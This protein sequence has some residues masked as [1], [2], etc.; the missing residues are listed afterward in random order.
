MKKS[1]GKKEIFCL[2]CGLSSWAV[3]F[4]SLL[5]MSRI[6]QIAADCLVVIWF[7]LS[8]GSVLLGI[9]SRLW[10]G[11]QSSSCLRWGMICGTVML[12]VQVMVFGVMFFQQGT[13]WDTGSVGLV[14]F[15]CASAVT[16]LVLFLYASFARIGQGRLD[17]KK[18]ESISAEEQ[19]GSF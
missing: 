18:A 17:H 3:C 8:V 1:V 16:A 4:V 6:P 5:L 15:A 12:F 14:A 10:M 13:E 9:F 2:V 19:G 11:K 7:L